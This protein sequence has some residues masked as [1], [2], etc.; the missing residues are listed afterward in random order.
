MNG[1][2]LSAAERVQ[3]LGL[4]P[5]FAAV[6]ANHRALLAEM[7]D[8]ERL[9]EGEVLFERGEPSDR[10]YVVVSG[11]LS[12]FVA[13]RAE[14]VRELGP[15]QLLGE[16][17]MFSESARTA[18]VRA[19]TEAVLLSLGYPR[20]RAFLLQFPEATLV[21]LQIA[22]ERLVASEARGSGDAPASVS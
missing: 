3:A 4:C 16:Y 13:A 19:A 6:P 17:G 9:R 7:M 22:I 18:T 10:I 5:V 12:V 14:P 2:S 8:T 21:L 11:R 15:G 20:F 1:T